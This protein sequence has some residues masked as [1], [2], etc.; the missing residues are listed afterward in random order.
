MTWNSLRC[1]GLRLMRFAAATSRNNEQRISTPD[2]DVLMCRDN[3][4]S[5][6]YDAELGLG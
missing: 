2:N 6:I 3:K 4:N 5:N 1:K